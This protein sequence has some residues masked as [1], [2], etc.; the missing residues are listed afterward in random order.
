MIIP[1]FKAVSLTHRS[2]FSPR[3]SSDRVALIM[4]LVIQST[5]L[6]KGA[7]CTA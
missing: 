1:I 5:E 4:E 7:E 3:I 6:R 2:H